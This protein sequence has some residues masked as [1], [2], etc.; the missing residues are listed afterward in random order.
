M[1][2]PKEVISTDVVQK[3]EVAVQELRKCIDVY[4]K[5]AESA[6]GRV[7]AGKICEFAQELS[8]AATF[9]HSA[10][11]VEPTHL[12]ARARYALVKLKAGQIDEGLRVATELCSEKPD[13]LFRS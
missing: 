6:D 7:A 11:A 8:V 5:A 13:Y 10:L 4:R 9:Y 1:I 2:M 12:E 3:A